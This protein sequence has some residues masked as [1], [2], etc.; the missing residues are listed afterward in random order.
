M[1]LEF[2]V[3]EGRSP[4]AKKKLIRSLFALIPA[5][6]GVAP[7]DLVTIFETS[8]ANRGVRGLPGDELALDY[9][10]GV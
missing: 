9:K 1:I 5:K 10:V 3:F 7:Q 8:Q 6:V 4:E 2:S